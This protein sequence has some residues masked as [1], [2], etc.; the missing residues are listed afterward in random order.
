MA[1]NDN[2]YQRIPVPGLGGGV[3]LTDPD[4]VAVQQIGNQVVITDL[5]TRATIHSFPAN[6]LRRV[7][8]LLENGRVCTCGQC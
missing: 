5:A 7:A 1:M 4:R 6:N 8:Q 2:G 3:L